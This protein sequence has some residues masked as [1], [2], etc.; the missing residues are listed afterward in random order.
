[1]ARSSSTDNVLA[2]EFMLVR[3]R[4]GLPAVEDS[5]EESEDGRK[6]RLNKPRPTPA[7]TKKSASGGVVLNGKGT[8]H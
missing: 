8:L 1:M 7:Q 2:N 5:D 4:F 3:Q 6:Q